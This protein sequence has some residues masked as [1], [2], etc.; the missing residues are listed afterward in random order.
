MWDIGYFLHEVI[1]LLCNKYTKHWHYIL[2]I[3]DINRL[4]KL[5]NMC[6]WLALITPT[7]KILVSLCYRLTGLH[8]C[9]A[10]QSYYWLNKL[11][12]DNESKKAQI[13]LKRIGYHY[14]SFYIMLNCK[15]KD[16][17]L[18]L[19]NMKCVL[20]IFAAMVKKLPPNYLLAVH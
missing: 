1:I 9:T 5:L 11:D 8:N 14:I 17:K 10:G 13:T 2:N 7:N 4:E 20:R 3:Y 15:N 6:Y 18:S 16:S 19:K 12:K